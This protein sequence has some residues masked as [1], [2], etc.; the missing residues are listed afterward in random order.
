M[1]IIEKQAFLLDYNDNEQYAEIINENAF[2]G[3]KTFDLNNNPT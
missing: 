2:I 1:S 3:I